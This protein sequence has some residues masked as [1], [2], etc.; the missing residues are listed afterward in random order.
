MK[1][2]LSGLLVILPLLTMGMV[3]Q[4][5]KLYFL[6]VSEQGYFHTSTLHYVSLPAVICILLAGLVGVFAI[7]KE[8]KVAKYEMS[9]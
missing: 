7:R 4:A 5:V 3:L 1:Y 2:L 9:K 6:Y 8:M